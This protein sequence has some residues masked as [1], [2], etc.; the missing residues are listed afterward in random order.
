M[1]YRRHFES[2]FRRRYPRAA[3]ELAEETESRYEAIAPEVSFA[4]TSSNPIDRRLDFCA[5]FLA[6]IQSLEARGETF[7]SIREYCLAV[8]HASV[9]PANA[10]QAWKKRLPAAL[11]RTPLV[12]LIAHVMRAK[13]GSKGH[14]DGFLIRVITAP[15]ETNGLGYGF[16][17]VECGICKLFDRHCAGRYVTILC[18]VDELTSALAGL[19]LVRGGTI[20]RGASVCDFRF[21]L[22][23]RVSGTPQSR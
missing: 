12:R 20:A 7:D 16:D 23:S 17:I 1:N 10:W 5:Y 18:E 15:E 22:R 19:E 4:R 2:E 13:G 21:R 14:D 11:M 9:S 6:A 3:R 8:T